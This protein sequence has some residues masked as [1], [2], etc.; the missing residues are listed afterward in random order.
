MSDNQ[1]FG[2]EQSSAGA[3]LPVFTLRP[4]S[5]WQ[6]GFTLYID[7][8]NLSGQVMDDFQIRIADPGFTVSNIWGGM[9]AVQADGSLLISGLDWSRNISAGGTLSIGFNGAG[10][11][12]DVAD[13]GFAA[14]IGGVTHVI[15][16]PAGDISDDVPVEDPPA[17][18]PP[19]EEPP[20]DDP[21]FV[22]P[23]AEDP[24]AEEPPVDDPPVEDTPVNDGIA[25][26]EISWRPGGAWNGGFTAHID[27]AN[28]SGQV[29]EAFEIRISDPAFSISNIWGGTWHIA[30]NGDLVIRSSGY[31]T[32][33]PVGQT[34]SLG[35]NG[36]GALPDGATVSY[37]AVI[38]GQ[39]HVLGETLPPG[40][41]VPEDD[42][43]G[44]DDG[45]SDGDAGD[46][47]TGGGDTGGGD[48]DPGDTGDGDDAGSGDPDTG[49]GDDG[50]AGGDTGTG[51][52][53]ASPSVSFEVTEQW[54]NGFNGRITITNTTGATLAD[55]TLALAEAGFDV[56]NAWGADY[57]NLASGGVEF[58]GTGWTLNMAP[59]A[60][61]SFGFTAA[62]T[63]PVNG[64]SLAFLSDGTGGT[65]TGG[66][67]GGGDTG[68]DGGGTAGGTGSFGAADYASALDMSMDFYYAQ[69]S[70]ALPDD[71]PISWRGDSAL[72]DGADVGRDL[73]GGWYDA[74]DHVKF[75]LPMAF[76]ATML[77]WGAA[78]YSEGYE[79]AGASEDILT[80][81]DWVT[82]YLMRCYDDRGT[83]DLSDDIFYA[84]VGNGGLDHSYWGA[85]EDMTMA[86]PAYAVTAN[87][88]GTE[89][90][91][92]AAAAMASSSI[93]FRE[94]GQI[95]KADAL[96]QK[97]IQL[98]DFA[99][100]YQG[101]YTNAVPDAQ[102]Y[103]N[104]FSGYQDELSWGAAWL[105]KATGDSA[106]LTKAE[107]HY[108]GASTT[109]ALGWDD[110]SNGV[111][112]LLAEVTGKAGYLADVD[113]HLA[114]MMTGLPR[115]PGTDSNAGLAW[116][117][118]WGAN[119]YAANMAFIAVQ[120]ANLAESTGDLQRAADL[121]EFASDQIDYMLGDN[122]SGQSYLVGFGDDFPLNPHHRGASG[123]TN[124]GS[125]A[126]NLHELTGA[127][128]GGPD[129][130]G[131]YT[132][133]R[134]DYVQN[135]VATDYNAGFSGALAGLLAHYSA[136]E[137][138]L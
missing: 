92:E 112:M 16:A 30:A 26:P 136:A 90:T 31:N 89:V 96:L 3:P 137:A 14:I 32:N 7:I 40:D 56:T 117:D 91:A 4:G 135:E 125:S 86:R 120:R 18:E 100:T 24:P 36:A 103:Y 57:T 107:A 21:P 66:S 127:L 77:A 106:Y 15:G 68:G 61:Q 111:A 11:L 1:P 13:V 52:G 37:V 69:Y 22:E 45:T 81:L 74:G 76:S 78:D 41:D 138:L 134:T 51:S 124:I 6:G 93:V 5:V 83:A 119:R 49:N 25:L 62:G 43:P 79:A 105:Y 130:W 42:L 9:A 20:A 63:V 104:S 35:F 48:A 115:T 131:N 121:F 58:G 133:S 28:T 113:A 132:D 19:V 50:G 29:L 116:L 60:V 88:P 123:T 47:D 98:Y 54:G 55:W 53:A 109:W 114:H 12:S 38:D 129:R 59:G 118:A 87:A 70:G 95:A 39:S 10:V 102:N 2:A 27:V 73:T 82:D 64:V 80:H 34:A 94:A 99:S 46:G 97:A 44:D 108:P 67:T 85:P 17:E 23:P 71:H 65:D 8:E 72:T 84:Q 122:P 126:N 128:V 101:T 33:L 75:N 110:K